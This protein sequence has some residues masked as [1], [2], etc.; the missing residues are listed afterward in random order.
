LAVKRKAVRPDHKNFHASLSDDQ[1]ARFNRLGPSLWS[2]EELEACFVVREK[3]G[4]QLAYASISRKE[5]G[6][7]SA[8]KLLS[9]DGGAKDR[10]AI[11]PSCRSYC[12]SRDSNNSTSE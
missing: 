11:S 7:R 2:V 4:Q 10:Q 9:K 3:N 8:A 6:R 1:K 5:P 12:R